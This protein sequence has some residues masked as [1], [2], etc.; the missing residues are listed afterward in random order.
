MANPFEKNESSKQA[1]KPES[2]YRLM[3]YNG[4]SGLYFQPK[5]NEDGDIPTP[6]WIAD[7]LEILG[8]SR[9]ENNQAHGLLLAWHDPD[10]QEHE[11]VCSF[12]LM[13]GDGAEIRRKLLD[14]GCRVDIKKANR[15]HLLKYLQEHQTN[16]V[17]RT[18]TK[19]GWF[20]GAYVLPDDVIGK[21]QKQEIIKLQS[22]NTRIRGYEVANTWEQWRDAVAIPCTGNSRLVFSIAAAFASPLLSLLD[23][24]GFGFHI[25]GHSSTG[26]S[27]AL[28]VAKSVMG[29]PDA[30]EQWRMTSNALEAVA[31]LH[32]DALLAL[33]EIGQADERSVGDI[34]Y[35]LSN[36]RGK[37]R[38]NRD[39]I[40]RE[41]LTWKIL[42]LSNGELSLSD[43][44]EQGSKK[45]MMAGQAVRVIEI[46][47]DAGQGLG[48]FEEVP[49]NINGGAAFSTY[50]KEQSNQNHG[51]VFRAFLTHLIDKQD[52]CINQLK[53]FKR[54]WISEHVALNA[55]GQVDR[56]ADAFATVAGAG[57]LATGMGLTGWASGEASKAATSCFN[58]WLNLRGGTGS[59]EEMAFLSQC[60]SLLEEFGESQFTFKDMRPRESRTQYRKGYRNDDGDFLILP[61]MFKN[62][63]CRG[64]DQRF[65]INVLIERDHLIPAKPD[66]NGYQTPS[67]SHRVRSD[68]GD[69]DDKDIVIR[70]YHIKADILLGDG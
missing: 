15:D 18:V 51:A 3:E 59:Q 44:I 27:T 69:I 63:L 25:R 9:D 61:Q 66:K 2:S 32:N 64:F 57:E 45:R 1:E 62:W 46:D 12:A 34:A 24:S 19:T 10:N 17:Y 29:S 70:A 20:N 47:A 36:G 50:L 68:K 48:I 56:V 30:I 31:A 55:D 65:C 37:Q 41:Q 8:R 38:Q 22:E 21:I 67:T 7:K 4:K 23:M 5:S 35:M 14:G 39:I 53:K 33:D 16:T 58:S 6:V 52:D 40:L 13:A 26:K 11:W 49:A 60:R 28:W 43:L 42:F 54:D